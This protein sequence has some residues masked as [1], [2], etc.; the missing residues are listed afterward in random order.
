LIIFLARLWGVIYYCLIKGAFSCLQS[1]A[2]EFDKGNMLGVFVNTRNA[3]INHLTQTR[4]LRNR[5]DKKSFKLY[6]NA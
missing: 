6:T 1:A 3:V 2:D 4:G 5:S